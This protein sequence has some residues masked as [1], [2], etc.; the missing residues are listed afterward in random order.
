MQE[1]VEKIIDK[2]EASSCLEQSTFD[3]DG[4]CND[5]GEEI[6]YLYTAIDVVNEVTKEYANS[7]ISR[8]IPVSESLPEGDVSSYLVTL[9]NGAVVPA[10]Y[11]VD[12]F[13]RYDFGENVKPFYESNPVIAWTPMPEGYC[14]EEI[15]EEE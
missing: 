3:D 8:W 10:Y 5:D 9:K 4:Y 13:V 7:F 1:F 2:L 6:V 15:E 11:L 14:P 12:E